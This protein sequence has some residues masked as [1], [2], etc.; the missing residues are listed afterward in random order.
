M[1]SAGHSENECGQSSNVGYTLD[2]LGIHAVG[3]GSLLK[4]SVQ[5]GLESAVV[6]L[7][8]SRWWNST[9]PPFPFPP[10]PSFPFLPL[11]SLS[12]PSSLPLEVDP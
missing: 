3:A 7:L 1:I 11:L 2:Q 4:H 5:S 12:L 9:F 8:K 6:K 10:S